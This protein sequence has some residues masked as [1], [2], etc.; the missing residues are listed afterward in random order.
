MVESRTAVNTN[1]CGEVENR[2]VTDWR[3]L[4]CDI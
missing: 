1:E 2:A 4:L 3:R